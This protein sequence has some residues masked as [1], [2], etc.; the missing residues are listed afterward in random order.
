M[1]S[2]AVIVQALLS[3]KL[4]GA[5]YQISVICIYYK[6]ELSYTVVS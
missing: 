2:L 4:D 5:G 6:P 3:L 1:K